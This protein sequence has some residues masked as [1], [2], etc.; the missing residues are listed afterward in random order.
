MVLPYSFFVK[1]YVCSYEKENKRREEDCKYYLSLFFPFLFFP[2]YS[3]DRTPCMHILVSKFQD[4][5]INKLHV[6]RK[7]SFVT[8]RLLLSNLP[9][10]RVTF[11]SS[12]NLDVTLEREPGGS[13]VMFNTFS[14]SFFASSFAASFAFLFASSMIFSLAF[15]AAF[16]PASSG[17]KDPSEGPFKDP[18]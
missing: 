10:T 12:T 8:F 7:D 13:A 18:N 5:N 9:M 17:F 4:K 6:A 1:F 15:S 14:T 11:I 2:L 16:I 3:P